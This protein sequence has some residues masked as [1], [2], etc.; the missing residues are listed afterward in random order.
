M[1]DDYYH[2]IVAC[3]LSAAYKTAVRVTSNALKPYWNDELHR[4]KE[5]AIEWHNIG[6]AAGKPKDGQ[7]FSIRC[8]TKLK[9]KMA[10]RDAY[11][12]F[13]HKQD[14]VIYEPF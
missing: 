13:E 9:Y 5:A 14:D 4:L 2:S 11:I 6:A 12:H 10:V 3:I 1:I 7:L 8:S